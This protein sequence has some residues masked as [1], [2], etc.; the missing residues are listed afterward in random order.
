MATSVVDETKNLLP[1]LLYATEPTCPIW[2]D[3]SVLGQIAVKGMSWNLTRPVGFS[4]DMTTLL[5]PAQALLNKGLNS[6]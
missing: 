4:T 1:A 5:T 6:N 3:S 2:T